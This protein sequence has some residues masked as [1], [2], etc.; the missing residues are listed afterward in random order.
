M[1]TRIQLSEETLELLKK[2]KEETHSTSYDETIKQLLVSR[3]CGKSFGGYLRPF[4]P[5]M[6]SEEIMKDLR[7]KTDRF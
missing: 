7:D 4:G 1:A 6:S 3:T 5:K 2:I